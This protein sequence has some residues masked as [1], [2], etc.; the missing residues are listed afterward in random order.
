VLNASINPRAEGLPATAAVS[1]VAWPDSFITGTVPPRQKRTKIVGSLARAAMRWPIGV[2]GTLDVAASYGGFVLAHR[3]TPYFTSAPATLYSVHLAAA[4]FSLLL[5]C[6]CY[7]QGLYDRH[8]FS[9]FGLIVRSSLIAS[10]LAL[11]CVTLG[12]NLFSFER[13]GRFVLLNAFFLSAGATIF[14]RVIARTMA[15]SA[16]VRLLFVGRRSSFRPLERTIRHRFRGFYH[17]PVYLRLPEAGPAAREKVLL[18]ALRRYDPDEVVVNDD[19]LHTIADVLRHASAILDLGC[20]IRTLNQYVE[21]MLG[22]MPI[23]VMDHR[24]VLGSGLR[25]NRYGTNFAKRSL[26]IALAA[27]GLIVGSPVMLLAAALVRLSGG[28]GPIIYKQTR[29]GRYGRTFSILKFRTMRVDAEKNGAV[30]AKGKDSRVTR[31]GKF[32]RRSRLD[33]LPQLWNI[34]R[35]DM[36]FVGPRPERPEFVGELTKQIPYYDLRHLVPPGLTGW[37]QVRYRYGA[38]IQDAERKLAYDLYY[39]RHYKPS[40]DLAICLR[41]I[42][43]M[44]KGAR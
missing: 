44:A 30:W 3:L 6:L 4:L 10:G 38:S 19:E 9:S 12:V 36:S 43:A 5:L 16:K 27:F 15:R 11:A 22:Q 21:E 23:E 35:G 1:S 37:A 39:V 25:N 31:A 2:W 24:A 40:F 13:V 41:T 18:Q 20:E 17:R 42:V 32:L 14:V 26:D 33:E 7:A 8:N 28:P 29:V 34:L